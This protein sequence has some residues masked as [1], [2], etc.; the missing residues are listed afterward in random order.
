[1]SSTIYVMTFNAVQK[2]LRVGVASTTLPAPRMMRS[3]NQRL[4]QPGL[5]LPAAAQWSSNCGRGVTSLCGLRPESRGTSTTSYTHTR[6]L[7][8]RGKTLS[9][10]PISNILNFQYIRPKGIFVGFQLREGRV[11]VRF[12][13]SFY[14]FV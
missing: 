1:M 4:Q 12:F 2:S 13:L 5:P 7:T 8:F 9:L 10:G 6:M 11:W 14:L 3:S